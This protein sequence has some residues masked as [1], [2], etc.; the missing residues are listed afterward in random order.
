MTPEEAIKWCEDHSAVLIFHHSRIVLA[1]P[2]RE[3]NVHATMTTGLK[4][5]MPHY[6]IACSEPGDSVVEVVMAGRAAWLEKLSPMDRLSEAQGK[7]T[8]HVDLKFST[9]IWTDL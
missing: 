1:I 4:L 3:M 2:Y 6:A 7:P 9:N 5:D 8:H